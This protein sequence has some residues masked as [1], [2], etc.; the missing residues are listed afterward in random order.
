[1]PSERGA[2]DD[3]LTNWFGRSY[4]TTIGGIATLGCGVLVAVNQ[5]VHNPILNVVAGVCTALGL[6]GA[7][8]VGIVAKDSRI[9]GPK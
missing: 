6:A 5:V 1:M 9:T 8:A 4:R 7:G 2:I 3:F